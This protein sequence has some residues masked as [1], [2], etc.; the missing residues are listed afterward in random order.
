MKSRQVS[1]IGSTIEQARNDRG[2]AREDLSIRA[3]ISP[4][5]IK[6]LEDGRMHNPSIK[7]LQKIADAFGVSAGYFMDFN[8]K[9]EE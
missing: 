6:R 2:W 7:T 5:T 8:G 3:G 1:K 4:D 9:K